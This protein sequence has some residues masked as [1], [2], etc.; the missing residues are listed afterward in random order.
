[1]QG[2]ILNTKSSADIEME[3]FTRSRKERKSF[4]IVSKFHYI[5]YI[6]Y[7]LYFLNGQAFIS[8]FIP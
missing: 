7:T 5:E 3:R 8:Y 4:F 2:S 1:M 6:Y